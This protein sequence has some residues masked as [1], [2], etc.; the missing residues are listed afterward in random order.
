MAQVNKK[1][2][3]VAN[4]PP[5]SKKLINSELTSNTIII[6]VDGGANCLHQYKIAP[7]YLLGD[8]DSI[9]QQA[10]NFCRITRA[11]IEQ[12]PP[13]KDCTDTRIALNKAILLGATE[14]IFLG[15]IG[16]VRADHFLGT[17]GLLADCKKLNVTAMLKDDQQSIVLLDKTTTILGN[18]GQLFSLHAYGTTVK[19]LTISGSKYPLKNY[20]LKMG[21]DLTI[22]NEF[23][24]S[25]VKI[26]FASG[27]I[28]LMRCN[29]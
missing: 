13:I 6:A 28:L 15:A 14:V 1:F 23:K 12:Y 16:G 20:A 22:S 17:I 5:P 4:G 26:Q 18:H 24:N 21:D 29:S 7:D 2:I 11:V 10:L 8:F 25:R 19:N 27:K 3:I 9:S